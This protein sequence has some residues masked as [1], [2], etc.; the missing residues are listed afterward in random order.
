M[1]DSNLTNITEYEAT[2][3]KDCDYL[4]LDFDGE[5]TAEEIYKRDLLLNLSSAMDDIVLVLAAEDLPTGTR[6]DLVRAFQWLD[7]AR[8]SILKKIAAGSRL[9]YFAE[10][11]RPLWQKP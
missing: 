1:T 10:Y 9:I 2:F 8:D 4:P 11:N 6:D 3:H 5:F 7:N